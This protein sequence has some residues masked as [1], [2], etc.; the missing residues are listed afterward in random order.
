[1]ISISDE[2]RLGI[3]PGMIKPGWEILR[4]FEVKVEKDADEEFYYVYMDGG[5][6]VTVYGTG[7]TVEEALD[8]YVHALVE[9]YE[10]T[11]VGYKKMQMLLEFLKEFVGKEQEEEKE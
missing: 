11:E 6:P 3:S 7:Y 5:P 9:C 1:M 4:P 8:D 10:R 2:G